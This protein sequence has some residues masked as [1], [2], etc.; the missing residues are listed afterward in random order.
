MW[1]AWA[2]GDALKILVTAGLSPRIVVYDGTDAP[3]G[4]VVSTDGTVYLSSA[5]D[6][7]YAFR[8]P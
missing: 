7:L 1:W 5:D 4:Y 8:P 3:R 2:E 6:H